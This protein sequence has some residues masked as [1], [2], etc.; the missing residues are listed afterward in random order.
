MGTDELDQQVFQRNKGCPSTADC[1][2]RVATDSNFAIASSKMYVEQL[3][4]DQ[5][6]AGGGEIPVRMLPVSIA[7]PPIEMILIKVQNLAACAP[8]T[9]D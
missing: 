7:S 8:P 2:R 4:A 9:N 1:V 6:D 3:L 5:F